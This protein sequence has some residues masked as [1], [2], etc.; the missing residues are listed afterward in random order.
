MLPRAKPG[1]KK[2][3]GM[4]NHAT[5][6][7]QSDQDWAPT[8]SAP[9]LA[10]I[11]DVERALGVGLTLRAWWERKESAASYAD[12]FEPVRTFNKADRV[13]GFFDTVRVDGR[14]LPVMGL[15]QEMLFDEPKQGGADKIRDEFREF[16]LHYFLRVSSFREPEP[17][18]PKDQETK[19]TVGRE[20]QPLS[21]CPEPVDTRRGFGYLQLYYKLRGSGVVGKFPR[22]LQPRIVDLRQIGDK[23]DWIVLQV[24]IFNFDFTY[25]PFADS[26]FSIVF[27]LK[28]ET[29]IVISPEFVVNRDNPTP[30]VLGQYGVGY[31]LLKPAPRKTIFAYGPGHFTAGLQLIDFQVRKDGQTGARLVFISNRPTQVLSVDLDPVGMSFWLAD[32][33]SLG[34]ASRFFGPVKGILEQFS[35]RISDF[36]PVTTYI[37]IANLLSGR[38]ASDQ[39]CASLRALE[40]NPMLITHFMEHYQLIVG[41]LMTWRHVQSW[42]DPAHIP[43]AVREGTS[44]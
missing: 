35:P 24:D 5:M 13:T 39:L 28:E 40:K 36:D 16:I 9:D 12:S 19:S 8:L 44:S 14:D 37:T 3:A 26:L 42:L 1:A 11:S 32:L 6:Q 2:N 21:F 41:A 34:A 31:A 38:I 29:Y 20:L 10:I 7:N 33:M 15:V 4:A 17:F 25:S 23:Y 22:H 18:I 43:E 27:P 30:E